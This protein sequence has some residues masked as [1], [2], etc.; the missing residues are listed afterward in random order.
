MRQPDFDMDGWCLEDG[1]QR[2]REHPVKFDIPD[3]AVREI[4]Q[5]GDFAKLIFKI[6]VDDAD[7]PEAFERMWV[8]V[9]N[10]VPGGYVGML[11]NEPSSIGENDEFWRGSELPFQPKHIIAVEHGNVES[12][13]LAALP[14]RRQWA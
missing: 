14:P 11:D 6:A 8:L 12:C 3:L 2:H 4:L 10:R 7:E 1:E 9:R 13:A 5:P